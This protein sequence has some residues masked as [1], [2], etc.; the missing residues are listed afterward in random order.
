ME[1]RRFQQV[2]RWWTKDAEIDLVGLNE[3]ENEI[4]FGEVKW[5][6]NQV[7]TDILAELRRKAPLVQWGRE[8]RRESFALFSRSGFTEELVRVAAEEGVSL[9]SL[10][11]IAA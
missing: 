2:G 6:V 10:E 8:G 3:E 11:E 4:L 7:G 5:S 9:R 1:G